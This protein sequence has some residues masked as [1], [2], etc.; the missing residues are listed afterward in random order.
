MNN[1]LREIIVEIE[2]ARRM[3]NDTVADLT[4]VQLDFRSSP[5][6]WSM[7]EVLDH[8]RLTESLV[9]DFLMMSTRKAK[10]K[11]LGPASTGGSVISS[12]DHF[13][14]EKPLRK[15]QAPSA[16]IPQPGI[17]KNKLLGALSGSRAKLLE[18]VA[19][20]A[21]YNLHE[22]RHPHPFLGELDLYQWL[23]L[24]GK[25]EQRHT[26]QVSQIRVTHGFPPG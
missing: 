19:A 15:V 7:G 24:V 25:H 11:K 4:Q 13:R 5:Q 8:L 18:A 14:I 22:L 3:L 20:V 21:P 17:A 12:L 9:A 2:G 16:V 6:S 10:E 23:L 1:K 26:A